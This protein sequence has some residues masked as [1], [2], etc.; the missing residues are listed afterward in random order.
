MLDRQLSRASSE[1]TVVHDM[2][3]GFAPD[4]ADAWLWQDVIASRACIGA[5]PDEFNAAGQ[6]WGIPP[7]DPHLLRAAAYKPLVETLRASMRSGGGVRI[8]HVMG[9][10]RLWG[11]RNRVI[12]GRAP[13]SAIRRAR[14]STS[15]RWRAFARAATSSARTSA[16]W[17]PAYARSSSAAACS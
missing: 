17:V 14:C 6:A 9:M 10:F 1:L 15:S 4:G 16:P 5:P 11:S 7:F 12:H 13:T 3:V 8:D 2:A